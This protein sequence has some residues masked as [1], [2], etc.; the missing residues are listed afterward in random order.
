MSET[1]GEFVLRRLHENGIRRIYGYPGDGING[2]LGGFH[3][4]GDRVEFTQVRHEEIASFAAS[5]HAKFTGEVGVC[6]ATSGPGAVHL[7]NGLYDAKLDH[8]PVVAIVGQQKTMSLGSNYQQEVDLISL[9]KDVASEFVQV[10]MSP[11]QAPALIDRAVQIAAAT[12]SPTAVIVPADVQEEEYSEPPRAHGA[13][14]TTPGVEVRSRLIPAEAELRRAAEVLN[15]GERVAILIGQGA[16][17][18]ADEVVQVAEILGAGVAKALNGRDVLP[19]QLPFVTGSIGLLGTKPSDEMMSGCDTLLMIGTSFPYSEWLPEPGSARAV[20]IDIDGRMV[21]IRYPLEVALTG[22]ARDSLRE[23][24]P[25]LE[26]KEDRSWQEEIED[27]VE[28]WWKIL[29]DRAH[30]SVDRGVNPTRVFH[31]L[32]PRL[33][34]RAILTSDSGS[35]TNWWARQLKLRKGMKAA[36]SG[37]LATMCPAIPYALAAKFA[38]PDR[39][40]IAAL[41]DGAMQMLGI[42]ALIDVARYWERW[43]SPQLLVIVLNNEDLNQV[44]WEQRVMSGDPKLDA[45]QAIPPFDYAGY[46][47]QLGLAG[48][49]VEEDAEIAGAIDEGLYAG[50][51]ALLDVVSDPEFP[52]LPPHIEMDQA[53]SM[54]KA[55]VKGDPH[56]GR[57]IRQSFKGKAKEF[58]NR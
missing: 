15:A 7:L 23:L 35:A 26:R 18:A 56:A 47:R 9:Y 48:M 52:P 43:E 12:R 33:P 13:V 44:T 27:G 11:E 42:N 24:I 32:S 49:R 38:Y 28:R 57:I 20:Q 16:R 2:I 31:E 10:C 1:V 53:V 46:A 54:A 34:D 45:S 55:I 25:L 51:P 30:Q 4:W 36:L 17:E 50:R 14:F 58:V 3:E 22:D 39:P 19:D 6:M 40:V 5:A 37:T 21:G 8:Q 41:G 29:E